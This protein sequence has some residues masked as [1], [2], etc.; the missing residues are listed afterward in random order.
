MFCRSLN[1]LYIPALYLHHLCNSRGTVFRLSFETEARILAAIRDRNIAGLVGANLDSEPPFMA[2]EYSD[3][4]DL[5]Q[6]L[7]D[8]VAETSLSKSPGV[9]TLRWEKSTGG[10]ACARPVYAL[11]PID[12]MLVFGACSYKLLYVLNLKILFLALGPW[13]TWPPKSHRGWSTSSQSTSSTAT[14]PPGK[15]LFTNR[16]SSQSTSST[17]TSPPGKQLFTSINFESINFILR[18]LATR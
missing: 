15:L 7:Q 17:A 14:L 13:C 5:N 10:G 9:A 18:N 8:H 12:K 2:C 11:L 16:T 1:F 4:G 3:R 6:Y